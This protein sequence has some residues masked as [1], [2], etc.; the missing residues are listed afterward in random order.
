MERNLFPVLLTETV[1][2][3]GLC[4]PGSQESLQRARMEP[5][6]LKSAHIPC[7]SV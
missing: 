3:E 5:A 1:E 4:G 7:I 6:S 2:A